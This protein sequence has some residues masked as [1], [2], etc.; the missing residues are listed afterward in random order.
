MGS[1]REVQGGQ[2]EVKGGR[3][4]GKGNPKGGKGKQREGGGGRERG[5]LRELGPAPTH[6]VLCSLREVWVETRGSEHRFRLRVSE[7]ARNERCSCEP[8]NQ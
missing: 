2:G 4:E 5:S 7:K 8:A 6:D 3:R 1:K